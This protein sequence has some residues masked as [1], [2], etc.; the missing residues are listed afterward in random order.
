MVTRK[1]PGRAVSEIATRA[2]YLENV[3][4]WAVIDPRE[5]EERAVDDRP[6][7]GVHQPV[8]E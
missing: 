2:E 4:R 8:G 1:Y 6:I 7:R 5:R 3:L